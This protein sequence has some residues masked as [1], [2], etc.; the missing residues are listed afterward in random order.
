VRT[1]YALACEDASVR[2]DGRVDVHGVF[3]QLYA[4]GFPA[5][6]DRLVLALAVEWDAGETGRQPFRIDL[7]D[8]S[9]SPALTISG[10]T[11]IDAHSPGAGPPQTRLIMPLEGIVFQ[12]AGTHRFELHVGDERVQLSPIHLIESPDA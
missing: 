5:Q 3:H 6:Q 12:A 8:P 1:L 4:P 11:D 9:G 10:H 2:E 7:V